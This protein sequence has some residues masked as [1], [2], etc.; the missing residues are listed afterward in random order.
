MKLD[1]ITIDEKAR[2][3][4]VGAGVT[5]GRWR[6][7]SMRVGM[8]CTTWLRCRTSLSPAHATVTHGSGVRNGNLA[9]A[10]SGLEFVTADGETCI[11][12]GERWRTFQAAL[13]AGSLGVVT[14]VTLDMQPTYQ[15]AQ[16]CTRSSRSTLE[17][18]SMRSSPAVTA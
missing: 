8:L 9:T 17:D 7:A 6:R 5:Y 18:P 4:T 3:V 13:W 12:E 16:S 2:T 10:V 1:E 15:V 14:R 11:I